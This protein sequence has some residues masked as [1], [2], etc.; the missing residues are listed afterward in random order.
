MDI[1]ISSQINHQS[2]SQIY[3]PS[4]DSYLLSE[5]LSNYISKLNKKE[6]QKIKILDMGAGSGI[7]TKTLL[8]QGIKPENI[9]AAD[10]NRQALEQI[11]KLGVKVIKSNLF[12]NINKNNKFDFIFFNPPYL[13][14][15]KYDKN[16]DTT[17]GKKGNEIIIKFLKQAKKYLNKKTLILIV[18]SSLSKPKEVEKSA[19]DMGYNLN[20]IKT[21]KLFFEKLYVWEIKNKEKNKK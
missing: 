6:K 3:Q 21:K 17:G 13:P 8:K 4:E 14:E 7:L 9:M 15:H 5:A 11:K 12:S 19:K 16:P 18:I 2:N 1:K 20:K 10:I